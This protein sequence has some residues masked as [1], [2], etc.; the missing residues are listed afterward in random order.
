MMVIQPRPSI[1]PNVHSTIPTAQVNNQ[2]ITNPP[3]PVPIGQPFATVQPP[4]TQPL[5][6]RTIKADTS[7]IPNAKRFR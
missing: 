7:K 3:K 1:I 5:T 4:L 6:P 2:I